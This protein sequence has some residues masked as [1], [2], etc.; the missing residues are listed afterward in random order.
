MHNEIKLRIASGNREYYAKAKLFKS[1]PLSRR[2]NEYLYSSYLR[3]V[4]T[5]EYETWLV[6]KEDEE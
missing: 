2:S 5:H 4:L 6:T 3:P 1:K